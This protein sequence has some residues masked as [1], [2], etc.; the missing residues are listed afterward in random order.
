MC[1][2]LG[3]PYPLGITCVH[4]LSRKAAAHFPAV[5]PLANRAVRLADECWG[6]WGVE[7]QSVSFASSNLAPFKSS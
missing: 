4:C 6:A 5:I 7:C 1:M 2:Q 3:E